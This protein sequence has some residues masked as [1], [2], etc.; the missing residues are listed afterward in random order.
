M[1]R[2]L[3][4]QSGEVREVAETMKKGTIPC[5]EVEY[6]EEFKIFTDRLRE[7]GIFQAICI[8]YDKTARDGVKEPEFEFRAAFSEQANG[9]AAAG[10][11]ENL[12][13]IDV[14][15]EAEM[16]ESYDPVGEM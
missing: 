14:F 10:S 6:F 7:F 3:R 1:F 2:Q 15:F 8:P 11:I 12:M 16:E 9:S 4:Y 5:L 13:Y